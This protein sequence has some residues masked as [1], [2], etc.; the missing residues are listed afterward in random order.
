MEQQINQFLQKTR[1]T[2]E[3]LEKIGRHQLAQEILSTGSTVAHI[4]LVA[5]GVKNKK[6]ECDRGHRLL[7]NTEQQV[8]IKEN[9][10]MWCEHLAND[11]YWEE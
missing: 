10:C 8:W 4:A 7:G 3:Y 6:I 9:Q 2:V 1:E 11:R 5:S